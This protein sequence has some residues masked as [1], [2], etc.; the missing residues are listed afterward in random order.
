[1]SKRRKPSP[2]GTRPDYGPL[3]EALKTARNVQSRPVYHEVE[4]SPHQLVTA[5]IAN[6]VVVALALRGDGWLRITGK[7]DVGVLYLKFKYNNGKWRGHY[8][9]AVVQH[10]QFNY[11]MLLLGSKLHKV[12]CGEMKPTKDEGY[13]WRD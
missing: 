4:P 10:W 13:N 12:D 7:D 11:G 8:V 3:I 1:M 9:M 2:D 6:Q 5:D